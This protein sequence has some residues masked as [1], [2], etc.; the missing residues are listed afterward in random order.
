MYIRSIIW[1]E[2][3]AVVFIL[4]CGVCDVRAQSL[5]QEETAFLTSL[6]RHRKNNNL[7]LVRISKT[8]CIVA[9]WM[10]TDLS[11]R[12]EFSHIDSQHRGLIQRLADAGYHSSDVR[13][14]ILG[15][16]QWGT[17]AFGKWRNSPGH[18]ANFL[19]PKSTEIGIARIY[20]PK[21]KHHW[22]WTC[23]LGSNITSF[24]SPSEID[25]PTNMLI[26]SAPTDA[27][28]SA[29]TPVIGQNE[30]PNAWNSESKVVNVLPW[31]EVFDDF[32]QGWKN[33]DLTGNAWNK[34]PTSHQTFSQ[35][36]HVHGD[37]YATTLSP[38]HGY[39]A[40]G[41]ATSKTF[42]ITRSY[43]HFLIGGGNR[44]EEC[45]FYLLVNGQVVYSATGNNSPILKPECWNVSNLI[46]KT[47]ELVI[48]DS[49]RSEP[50]G[51]IMVD[52]IV[53][54]DLPTSPDGN[55][56]MAVTENGVIPSVDGMALAIPENTIVPAPYQ[57]TPNTGYR[58][59]PKRLS[60]SL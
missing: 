16:T 24:P 58:S 36:N 29:N 10:S 38:G 5:D 54:S 6:N 26:V 35:V 60:K 19:C 4:L 49:A 9:V 31:F 34:T 52:N 56:F 7:T 22:Y 17:D 48:G 27:Q 14:N 21:S 28:I 12:S 30:M 3:I 40:K 25:H 44:P 50:R 43:I 47:A 15:G 45:Y 11:R 23:I 51:Y 53:F 37:Y 59:T 42:T 20:S 41:R 46:G 2:V 39:A 1:T 55:A 18:N 57:T 32:E 8:L 13:E 33:W